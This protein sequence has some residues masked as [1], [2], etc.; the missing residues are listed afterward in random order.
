MDCSIPGFVVHHQLP[1]L[2]Q[3]HIHR[4]TD[5][6]QPPY[7]LLPPSP[8]GFN[9][10]Q[11]QS[12]FRWVS[13]LHQP[14]YWNF[15]FSNSPSNKYSGLISF[16]TDQFDFLAAQGTLKSL[17][18]HHSSK[19]SVLQH[20]AF[21]MVHLSHSYMTTGKTIVLTRWVF[22]GKP[23]SLLFNM[24]SRLV[25]AFLTR[26][27]HLLISW[28][29]SPSAVISEPRKIK[30]VTVSIIS[31]SICLEMMR[32]DVMIFVFWMLS[33]KPTISLSSFTFIKRLF[34]S[35]LLSALRVVSLADLR[36]VIFLFAILIPT[37]DSSSQSFHMMYSAYK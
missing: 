19:A 26:S 33:F 5:V 34:S 6:I 30:S 35:C 36:S 1:E 14:K 12:L 28:L 29:Q 21:F 20:S 37:C 18:Q 9:L 32:P 25:I 8:P 24:L 16:R 7:P 22:V 23:I 2:A 3:T 11:H 15:S 27:K 4:V 13:F 31:P 17:L 10:S